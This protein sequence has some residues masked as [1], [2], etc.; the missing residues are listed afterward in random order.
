MSETSLP[1]WIGRATRSRSYN[2]LR[3][4]LACELADIAAAAQRAQR[5]PSP[6]RGDKR[7]PAARA[8]AIAAHQRFWVPGEGE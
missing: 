2:E 8:A 7:S 1:S 4:E 5:P 3:A 6:A